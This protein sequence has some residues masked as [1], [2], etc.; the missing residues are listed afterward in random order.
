MK[1][2]ADLYVPAER[3]YRGLPEIEYPLHDRTA[4]ITVC[5]RLCMHRKKI[6]ISTCLAGQSVGIKEVDNSIWLV[7]FMHYD[8]GYVDLEQ[9]TSQPLDNP[10]SARLL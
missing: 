8:L 7:S 10:F 5:G 4:L 9:K 1:R 6:N 3:I 2:P